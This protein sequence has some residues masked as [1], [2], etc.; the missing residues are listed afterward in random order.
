MGTGLCPTVPLLIQLPAKENQQNGGQVLEPP[1]PHRRLGRNSWL[2]PGLAQV[3]AANCGVNRWMENPGP[4][5]LCNCLSDKD[6]SLLGI[7]QSL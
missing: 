5:V 4:L 2:Q 3:I 6:K 7:I 1:S